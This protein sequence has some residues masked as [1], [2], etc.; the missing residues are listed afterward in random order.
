MRF[1]GTAIVLAAAV[2]VLTACSGDARGDGAA[3]AA[4]TAAEAAAELASSPSGS[5]SDGYVSGGSTY[6]NGGSSATGGA[7]AADGGA[8]AASG[9]AAAAN[10]GG[11]AG[12]ALDWDTFEQR[13]QQHLDSVDRRLRRVPNLTAAERTALRRDVNEL[14]IARAR[15]LGVRVTAGV[16]AL[17]RSG[18][19][20]RLP[21]TTRHWVVRELD[22]S[23]P[24]VTPDTEAM[25]TELG[26]RFH[27]RLDS[28]GVP[29]YRLD[30]TS[31]LRTPETQA[32]LRRRNSNASQT[33]SSHEFGTTLDIAY[34]RFAAPAEAPFTDTPL[35]GYARAIADSLQVETGR[36]RGA[37]LQ[38][39][40]GRVIEAMQREGKLMVV[41]ERR[42]TVYHITVGRR[43]PQQRAPANSR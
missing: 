7:A 26:T 36:L 38:A 43:Y 12:V 30:I 18:R 41:M 20:V 15:Q 33:E 24:F 31:V 23:V 25:L 32:E 11:E 40:L 29:R 34:R 2:S 28:L 9:G 1:S 16:D 10:G 14:Q 27:A 19:L 8:P 5:G 35:P 39:V 13:L 17:A 42:Q 6:S 22:Y 3:A 4:A 37:E 21:D